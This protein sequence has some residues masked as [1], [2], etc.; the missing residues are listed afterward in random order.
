MSCVNYVYKTEGMK[1]CFRGLNATIIREIPGFSAYI[2]SYE[3]MCRKVTPSDQ[4]ISIR[5]MF[6]A[7]GFAGMI[8][9]IINIPVDVI[10]TRLQTDKSF[11]GFWDC[12]VKSYKADGW[13]VFYRGLPA[14]CLRAFPTNAVTLTVYSVLLRYIG[15]VIEE[16]RYS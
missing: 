6:I 3:Y 9:W 2:M 14:M 12:L 15:N 7:G 11:R 10:K 8:S 4:E 16:K 13:T 1:G 5:T